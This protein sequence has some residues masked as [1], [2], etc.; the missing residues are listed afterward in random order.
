MKNAPYPVGSNSPG[1]VSLSRG[2]NSMSKLASSSCPYSSVE[3]TMI[4][5]MALLAEVSSVASKLI[6]L[7]RTVY[8]PTALGSQF[9]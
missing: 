7:A 4:L 6:M 1:L 3:Y 2:V 9:V 8:V 5:S